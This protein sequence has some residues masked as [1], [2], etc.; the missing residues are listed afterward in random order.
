M[1]KWKR[2]K[3]AE[4]RREKRVKRSRISPFGCFPQDMLKEKEPS[5]EGFSKYR[6]IHPTKVGLSILC[7][8]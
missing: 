3:A 5:R 4:F 6:A 8:S 2:H 7:F 1:G